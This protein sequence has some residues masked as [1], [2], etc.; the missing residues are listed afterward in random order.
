MP[1]DSWEEFI[2][3]QDI[4]MGWVFPIPSTELNLLGAE[5]AE[6]RYRAAFFCK[7]RVG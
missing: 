2:K 4:N 1:F 7:I 3:L 5:L 6:S